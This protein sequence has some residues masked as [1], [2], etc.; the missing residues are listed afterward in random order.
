MLPVEVEYG[1]IMRFVQI[2]RHGDEMVRV[3]LLCQ[4]K[5]NLEGNKFFDPLG[6]KFLLQAGERPPATS[7]LRPSLRRGN[8]YV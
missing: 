6:F 7:S 3:V 1:Q 8:Q 5:R 4:P 2:V